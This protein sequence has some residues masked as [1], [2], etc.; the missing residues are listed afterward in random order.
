MQNMKMTKDY[1]RKTIVIERW[2]AADIDRVWKAWTTASLLERWWGPKEWPASSKSFAFCPGGH[3][4]YYMTGPDGTQAWGWVDYITIA[5]RESFTAV[6]SFCDAAGVKN[7]QF[8]V[9]RWAVKFMSPATDTVAMTVTLSF[10]DEADM[11]KLVEM[12]F[13]AGFSSALCNLEELLSADA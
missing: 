6:D 11:A 13:E 7:T 9:T 1:G 12:G 3:W 5:D 8:P 10:A 2:F 4:H